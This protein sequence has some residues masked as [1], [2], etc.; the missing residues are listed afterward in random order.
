MSAVQHLNHLIE[1]LQAPDVFTKSPHTRNAAKKALESI[2]M[3]AK[4]ETAWR[5]LAMA[6]VQFGRVFDPTIGAR[7]TAIARQ[8]LI[9]LL[10]L[11]AKQMP[12][13][14]PAPKSEPVLVG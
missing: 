5:T 7:D 8:K 6:W 2:N 14:K 1:I 4:G 13:A 12:S 9:G 10:P 3:L 11:I